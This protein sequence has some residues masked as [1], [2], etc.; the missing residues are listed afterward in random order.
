M[1]RKNILIYSICV[2]CQNGMQLSAVAFHIYSIHMKR[3]LFFSFIAMGSLAFLA[4]QNDTGCNSSGIKG[5]VYFVSGNRMPSPDEP[6]AAPKGIKTKLFVYKLTNLGEVQKEGSS[7]FYKSI[8]TELVKEITT[9]DDGSYKIK[10]KPGRYSLFVKKD[11]LFYSNL[12]DAENNIHPVEVIKG[13]MT[14]D[15]FQVDYGAVY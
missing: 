1:I 5:H 3:S 2:K 6:Q 8:S 13:K 12:F 10:L 4:L 14:R 7:A 9:N 11:D 15:D